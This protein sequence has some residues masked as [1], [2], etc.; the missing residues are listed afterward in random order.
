MLPIPTKKKPSGYPFVP[1]HVVTGKIAPRLRCPIHRKCARIEFVIVE[2]LSFATE[3]K[4][5]ASARPFYRGTLHRPH[6]FVP[7][8]SSARRRSDTRSPAS[9]KSSS[10]S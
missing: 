9:R 7:N 2:I 1:N 5:P 4:G 3:K 8:P 6:H 10:P